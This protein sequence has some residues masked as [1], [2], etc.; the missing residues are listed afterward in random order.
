VAAYAA[1]KKAKISERRENR[2][3]R[4]RSAALAGGI[5]EKIAANSQ[6]RMAING[7]EMAKAIIRISVAIENVGMSAS[8]EAW[9]QLVKIAEKAWRKRSQRRIGISMGIG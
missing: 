9:R 1:R 3:N 6:W 8:C 5:A 4:K 7:G 2:E